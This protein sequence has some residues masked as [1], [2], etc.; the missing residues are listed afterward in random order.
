MFMQVDMCSLRPAAS[1]PGCP[2]KCATCAA[3][4]QQETSACRKALL[5]VNRV[6]QMRGR[7]GP[8][9][10]S[11]R[12][13]MVSSRVATFGSLGGAATPMPLVLEPKLVG[14]GAAAFAAEL[15]TEVLASVPE[16]SGEGTAWSP[17]DAL[18]WPPWLSA[19]LLMP[20]PFTAPPSSSP[21]A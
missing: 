3:Y 21:T 5:T 12:F 14:A 19:L 10:A 8:L 9:R 7:A 15:V 4:P 20:S 17:E 1:Q 2:A 13:L 16:D 18:V 11:I 6:I